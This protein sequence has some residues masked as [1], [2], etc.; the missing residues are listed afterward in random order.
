MAYIPDPQD[1]TRPT[2]ADFAGNMAA[3]FRAL[4]GY[5]QSLVSSGTNFAYIG[6]ARNRFNNG[7]FNIA[8]RGTSVTIAA[9]NSGIL[10]DNWLVATLGA[11][12]LVAQ[13]FAGGPTTGARF[14]TISP[15]P[16]STGTLVLNRIESLNV[17]DLVAGTP[18]TVSGMV[19][20]NSLAIA[21]PSIELLIPGATDNWSVAP[22]DIGGGAQ[23]LGIVGPVLA[24]TWLFFHN[25][26]TLTGNAAQGLGAQLAWNSSAANHSISLGNFQL[27]KGSNYTQFEYR[28]IEIETNMCQR[29]LQLLQYSLS[30]AGI[31]GAQS[32]YLETLMT[33]M[34][35]APAITSNTN[36]VS[37][38]VTAGT[39]TTASNQQIFVG[40][41]AVAS[42]P[43]AYTGLVVLSAEL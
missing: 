15:F 27:E 22:V 23:P 26:F 37:T 42:G 2:E 17:A 24:N 18:V 39:V 35:G 32:S 30:G 10:L 33:P 36:T 4:K 14:M 16:G 25:T 31:A 28:P 6:G 41:T 5:I 29:Q 12:C 40:A 34:R 9:G 7:S 11:Q 38:N 8:Q 3:E 19:N 1:P 20:I 43:I 21:A 13:N